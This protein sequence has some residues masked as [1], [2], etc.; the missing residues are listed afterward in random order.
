MGVFKK[1]VILEKLWN[2]LFFWF[3]NG[4]VSMVY[5]VWRYYNGKF[6]ED[7]YYCG[8]DYVDYKGFFVVVF[9]VGCIVLVGLEF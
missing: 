9:V 2:G 5:G 4:L 1:F 7:Y 8:V 3:N 6:V